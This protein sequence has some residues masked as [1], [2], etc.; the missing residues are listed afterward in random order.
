MQ[1]L[2]VRKPIRHTCQVCGCESARSLNTE[3]EISFWV[4][5]V[6]SVIYCQ[7]IPR[8]VMCD[9]CLHLDVYCLVS[10]HTDTSLHHNVWYLISHHT[11][12]RDVWCQSTP[13]CVLSDVGCLIPE[14]WYHNVWWVMS[15]IEFVIVLSVIRCVVP[16]VCLH[17]NIVGTFFYFVFF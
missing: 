8:C 9:T 1:C 12:M 10:V 15:D 14:V 17:R 6:M 7:P 2:L 13:W 3:A 11:A 16:D 4:Y 5:T